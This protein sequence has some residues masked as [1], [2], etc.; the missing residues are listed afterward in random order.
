MYN[1]SSV[2]LNYSISLFTCVSESLLQNIRRV[3]VIG[4]LHFKFIQIVMN[5]CMY[6][7]L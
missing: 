4:E 2:M 3:L 6:V 7:G 5:V 1:R